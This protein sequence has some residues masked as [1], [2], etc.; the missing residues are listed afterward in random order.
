MTLLGLSSGP[1]TFRERVARPSQRQNAGQAR[2]QSIRLY[3]SRFT[4]TVSCPRLCRW[5]RSRSR[6]VARR[7]DGFRTRTR[8]KSCLLL[9]TYGVIGSRRTP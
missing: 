7:I 1:M 6:P 3:Q 8:A 9:D 2:S 5:K 4:W